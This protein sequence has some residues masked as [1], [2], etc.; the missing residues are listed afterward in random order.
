MQVSVPSL[1]LATPAYYV[2]A[3]SEASS[4][5]ARYDGVRYGLSSQ[6]DPYLPTTFQSRY[7]TTEVC[8]YGETC[9]HCAC[10]ES[11]ESS[12]VQCRLPSSSTLLPMSVSRWA[13]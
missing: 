7:S 4:N 6:V 10:M 5:L 12:A 11:H 3:V 9:K 2:L 13:H 1:E 8:S